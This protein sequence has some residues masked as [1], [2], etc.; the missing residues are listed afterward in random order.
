MIAVLDLSRIAAIRPT[1]RVAI[2][3]ARRAASIGAVAAAVE[4]VAAEEVVVTAIPIATVQC[5]ILTDF[6]SLDSVLTNHQAMS[7]T[8]KPTNPGASPPGRE[9]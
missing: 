6:P 9:N 3:T 1:A 7:T 5:K 4:D 2:P 8:S